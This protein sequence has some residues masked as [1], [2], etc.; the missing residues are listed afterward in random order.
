M[1]KPTGEKVLFDVIWATR[2]HVC[3]VSG[4]IIREANVSCFMHIL[5][6]GAYPKFRLFDKNI[7]LV[8]P[9]IHNEYDN[10]DRSDPKFYQV[11]KLHD[12]LIKKY[13]GEKI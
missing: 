1:P 2:P 13:Y 5:S 10:G 11:M 6:K 8:T 4:Q 7:L 3:E 12:E 9:E